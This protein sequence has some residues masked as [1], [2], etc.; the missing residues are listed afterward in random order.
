MQYRV[1]DRKKLAFID[2]G[3]VA[4]YEIDD[5]YIVNNNSSVSII[6]ETNAAEGD[7]I[8]LIKTSGAFHKGI[9]TSVDNAALTIYYK[10]DKELFNDNML[11]LMAQKF[12]GDSELEVAGSIGLTEVAQILK[13]LF[14]EAEDS[15][16]GQY[17]DDLKTLPM[18]IVTMG[19]AV[20]SNGKPRILWTWSEDSI[21]IV[22]WIVELFEKYNV[23]LNWTID[24]DTTTEL[25]SDR[26]PKYIVTLSAIT[27]SGGIIKDNVAMQTISYTKEEIP[28]ATVCRVIDSSTKET[29]AV[30]YLY[31]E[32][33]T[34]F[35]S[36][37]KQISKIDIGSLSRTFAVIHKGETKR[38]TMNFYGGDILLATVG[39]DKGISI[40]SYNTRS[41]TLSYTNNTGGELTDYVIACGIYYQ[42]IKRVLPVKT[43][44]TSYNSESA[45]TSTT[46]EEAAR[47]ALIPSRFNQA[48]EIKINSDSKM[49][50]FANAR[51]GDLYKIINE[52]GTID[53]VYTG[54]KLSSGNK[55][56]T[57]YFGLGRQNYTDLIQIQLRKQRYSVIYN[58]KRNG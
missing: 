44:I 54:K 2:G 47:D 42:T 15:E 10:S 33:G 21:N 51:F 56:A 38:F 40:L 39:K 20:D 55:F 32:N 43:V 6:K 22:D 37:N 27:N 50:D 31:D 23:T 1:Y 48:I 19:D 7:V 57:L 5:D 30:Y 3:Y 4:N 18:E 29:L 35:I 12:A 34:Y 25:L 24:F 45:T 11:N 52:Y 8:V 58:Q 14:A 36:T 13:S 28:D 17:Y 41:V 46:V 26:R 53:S 9:I 16:Q 49:F